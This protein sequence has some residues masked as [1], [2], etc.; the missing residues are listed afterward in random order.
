MAEPLEAP[1]V[2]ATVA[3]VLLPVADVMVGAEG[4]AA[5]GGDHRHGVVV[6]VG[7]VDGIGRGVEGHSDGAIPHGD[8]GG[9]GDG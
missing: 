9:D 3:W 7:D 6:L 8:R 4:T 1:S 2:Q 5:G